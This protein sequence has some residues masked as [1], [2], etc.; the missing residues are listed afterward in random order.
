MFVGVWLRVEAVGDVAA[1]VGVV[2]DFLR[3]NEGK[4]GIGGAELGF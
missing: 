1:G 3:G 2:V 4:A